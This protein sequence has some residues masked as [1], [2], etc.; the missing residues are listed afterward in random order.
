MSK[1]LFKS[2]TNPEGVR[3]DAEEEKFNLTH[4]SPGK[5]LARY[6]FV[7]RDFIAHAF[8]WSHT[9]EVVLKRGLVGK[10]SVMDVGCGPEWS[11]LTALHSSACSPSYFLGLDAR[12]CSSTKPNLKYPVEF[13]QH[14]VTNPMPVGHLVEGGAPTDWKPWDIIVCYEVIEHMP[15]PMGIKL[16]DNIK[17]AMSENTLLLFSTPC[18]DER[19]G[20]AEN[21]IYEWKYNELREELES[22]FTLENHFGTFASLRDYTPVMSEAELKM[23][24]RLKEYYNSALISCLM[25]PLYPEKARNCLWHLKLKA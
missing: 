13:K 24:A 21:H 12:D 23:L 20:M 4:L 5:E 8:R 1:S 2:Q 19:V 11:Q 22:R 7:H 16:L 3:V 18:F 25:A 17:S 6:R 15:K 10:G 9:A 14:D